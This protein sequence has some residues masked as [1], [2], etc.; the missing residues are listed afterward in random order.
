MLHLLQQ[1][2]TILLIA[3][4][5][6]IVGVFF[7]NIAHMEPSGTN[8]GLVCR[9]R[10]FSMWSIFSNSLVL[11]SLP[12]GCLHGKTQNQNEAFNETI[13]KRIPKTKFVTLPQLGFGIF[14]AVSNFNIGRKTSVLTFEKLGMLPGRY[15]LKGCQKQN[16]GILYSI[17]QNISRTVSVFSMKFSGKFPLI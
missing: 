1:T 5:V 2:T 12:K 6:R 9:S 7:N 15:M 4:L 3:L 11:K 8:Q 16:C 10:L 13:W 14:D 17:S